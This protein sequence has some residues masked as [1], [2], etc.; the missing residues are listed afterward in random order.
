MANSATVNTRSQDLN[1]RPNNNKS[2]QPPPHTALTSHSTRTT[3]LL[4]SAAAALLVIASAGFGMLFAWRVSSQHDT[5]LGALSVAMV[6][7]PSSRYQDL[8]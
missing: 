1:F 5:L 7:C 2:L 8:S 4:V 3:R 6:A